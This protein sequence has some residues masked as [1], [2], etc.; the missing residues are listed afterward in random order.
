MISLKGPKQPSVGPE[1]AVRQRYSQAADAREESLCCPVDYD[2]QFLQAIPAEVIERDYGCGDPSKYVRA[3]ETVLDLGSGG[4]KICFIAAQVVGAR[5]KVIGVDMNDEMLALARRSQPAVAAK[6]GYDNVRFLKGK[7]QD[8][9][10]D[11]DEVER[12][13]VD[14]PIRGERDLQTFEDWLNEMRRHQPMIADGS[15]DVVV[16]NCVLNLVEPREKEQLFEEIFRVLRPGGRAVISDIVSD[17]EVPAE[18][19]SD[20]QL[21]SG[22]ISGAFEESDF[23]A[24]FVAVGFDVQIAEMAAQPWQ[25]VEGI[26]FRSMTVVAHKPVADSAADPS[27]ESPQVVVYRGPFAAVLDNQGTEFVRGARVE[28]DAPT[29][30]RL[31]QGP[32]ADHFVTLQG[33]RSNTDSDSD[34]E[35][36]TDCGCGPGCC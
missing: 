9:A 29:A 8:L 15:I 16:S 36:A 1:A 27:S 4:G 23:L 2:S 7:I 22:C 25:I 17:C 12:Y 24:Q 34:P 31:A 11:R 21:W 28:V 14:N 32:L 10:I 13:L 33:G 30:A 20:A 5:G 6:I 35:A 19:Q 18:M 26:E 3:E